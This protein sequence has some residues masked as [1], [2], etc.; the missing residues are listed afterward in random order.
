MLV[1]WDVGIKRELTVP[2][3]PQQNGVAKRKRWLIC[4]ATKAMM[5]DLDLPSLLWEKA[6]NTTVYVQNKSSHAA[7]GDNTL[8]EAF[9]DEKSK[10]GHLRIFECLMYIHVSKEKRMKMDPSEKKGT[11]VGYNE[12]TKAY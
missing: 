12:T 2:Y 1:Y 4:E 10:V 7:L 8:E 3:N 6:S 5:S 9:T 11:F